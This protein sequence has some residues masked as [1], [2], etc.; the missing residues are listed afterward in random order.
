METSSNSQEQNLN[1]LT[2]SVEVSPVSQSAT[3]GCDSLKK[4]T[5]GYGQ[6]SFDY[7][8]Y[9]DRDSCSW[10][11]C[12]DYLPGGEW[13]QSFVTWPE[14]GW[15]HNGECFQPRNM[16][17]GIDETGSISLPTP[18]AS[19]NRFVL[20]S[21]GSTLRNPDRNPGIGKKFWCHPDFSEWLMGFPRGWTD[22]KHVETPSFHK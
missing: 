22:L 17:H 5:D 4:I 12:Q 11:T 3:Q 14:S 6:K 8:A 13:T 19:D 18:Q 2:L 20:S 7:L 9:F 21:F 16:E 1:P 15:M 10:K